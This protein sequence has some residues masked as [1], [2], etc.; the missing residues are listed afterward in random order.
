MSLLR[1]GKRPAAPKEAAAVPLVFEPRLSLAPPLR[2]VDRGPRVTPMRR[3]AA[4]FHL[5]DPRLQHPM[6]RLENHPEKNVIQVQLKQNDVLQ[7]LSDEGRAEL[8]AQL[9]VVDS[10]KGDLLLHQGVR[11][12]EQYFILDGILKRVVSNPE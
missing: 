8:A 3:R 9:V 5:R 12:M 4:R 1:L 7:G 11:E 6:T 2:A 10:K